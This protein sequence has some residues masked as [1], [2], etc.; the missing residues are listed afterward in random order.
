MNLAEWFAW[1]NRTGERQLGLLLAKDWEPFKDPDFR[2]TSESRLIE[3]G[4][5]LHEGATRVDVQVYLQDLRSPRWPGAS[6]KW[7]TRDRRT[8]E[9]IIVWYREAT[10]E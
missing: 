7:A 5:K 4:R 6:R 8:A 2:Q 3:L 10:Q 1:W 9:R